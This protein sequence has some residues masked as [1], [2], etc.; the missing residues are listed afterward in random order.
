MNCS[1]SFDVPVLIETDIL[2]ALIS[3]E[4]KHHADAVTLLDGV[5]SGSRLSPYALIE[6]DLLLRSGEIIVREV[7][8]FYTA[9][10]TFFKYRNIALLSAKP[11]YH[12]EAH[13][14]REKYKKL[15]YFDSLHAAVGIIENMELVSY[16][17]GYRK[18][19]ELKYNHP[20]KYF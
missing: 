5:L 11:V 10:S 14:L 3:R 2:L 20:S 1:A 17:K 7:M 8:S 16:D 9:L 18:V 4:D 15:T 13:E 6:L 19:S 12:G